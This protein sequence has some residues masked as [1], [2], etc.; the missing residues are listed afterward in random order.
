[1]YGKN[2]VRRAVPVSGAVTI[3]L[4]LKKSFGW[5]DFSIKVK[6]NKS[7][8]KRYAGHVETGEPSYSDP[9]MGQYRTDI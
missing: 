8:I 2:K 5:Y 9:F 7:F 4:D 1:M 6:G 3:I